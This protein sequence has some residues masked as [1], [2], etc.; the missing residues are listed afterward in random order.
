M[1]MMLQRDIANRIESLPV[2]QREPLKVLLEAIAN[3]AQERYSNQE[4]QQRVELAIRKQLAGQ[5]HE[6]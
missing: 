6:D 5:D 3:Q 2:D 1:A 4:I